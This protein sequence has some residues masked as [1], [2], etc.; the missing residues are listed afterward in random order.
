MVFLAKHPLVDKY[1]LSSINSIYCGAAPLSEDV[2]NYVAKRIGKNKQIKVLQGYGMTEL[3][4]LVTIHGDN[5]VLSVNGSVGKL[6]SGMAGKV[7]KIYIE[8]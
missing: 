4:I 5:T 3:S 1:N 6:I 2:Q 8:L 7:C